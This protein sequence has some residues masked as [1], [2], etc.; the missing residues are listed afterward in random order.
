M[1]QPTPLLA[2]ATLVLLVPHREFRSV[3]ASAPR[4]G[5]ASGLQQWLSSVESVAGVTDV[6]NQTEKSNASVAADPC[7]VKI[8]DGPWVPG[9]QN[10]QCCG[11]WTDCW[12]D[13][14]GL[15][16]QGL[17][18]QL[19]TM[20]ALLRRVQRGGCPYGQALPGQITWPGL[21]A[22]TPA[23][24]LQV[25]GRL[26]SLK[27]IAVIYSYLP[28]GVGF[29][30]VFS[31]LVNRGTRQLWV[32]VWLCLQ[33]CLCEYL[34]KYIW[35]EPR[36]GMKM[37]VRDEEGRY[38]GSCLE[39]CGMP[40]SH[41]ALAMGWFVLLFLD[42]VFRVSPHV[43]GSNSM[44]M[45]GSLDRS[46]NPPSMRSTARFCRR[47]VWNVWRMTQFILLVPWVHS[48]FLTQTKFV[49]YVLMWFLIMI[50]VPFMR[51][52]LY[53]HTTS[54]VATGSL[55]GPIIAVIWWRIVRCLQ[56]RFRHKENHRFFFGLLTHNYTLPKGSSNSRYPR[57]N[58]TISQD[59][60]PISYAPEQIS[61]AE[62]S[63]TDCSIDVPLGNVA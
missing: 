29:C 3:S 27:V 36:P 20:P 45:H 53:D 2:A 9:F 51:V 6:G 57:A 8:T 63:N 59:S 11:V 32:L 10:K 15:L 44:S 1:A 60:D 23:E 40:S 38:V 31:F 62:Q 24:I 12:R 37:Q 25:T 5:F 56:H 46:T 55:V 54:Q 18:A 39:S 7:T 50:P 58:S 61:Q 52:A 48:E 4:I 14:H 30:V 26:T 13:K 16:P 42:A 19:E 28:Y 33:L 22:G 41:S 43:P 34:F 17:L 47:E 35:H 21:P 49:V